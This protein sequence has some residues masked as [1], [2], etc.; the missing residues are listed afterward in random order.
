MTR[1]EPSLDEAVLNSWARAGAAP[2][3]TEHA[4][5]ERAR[6]RGAETAQQ[7]WEANERAFQRDRQRVARLVSDL[8]FGA[9]LKIMAKL[10]VAFWL[11]NLLI[12]LAVWGVLVALGGSVAGLSALS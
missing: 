8:P 11:A 5:T 2:P 7:R 3:E 12:G 1:N 9:V 4:A 6:Q 10:I